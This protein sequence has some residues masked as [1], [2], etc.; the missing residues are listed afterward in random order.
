MIK[1]IVFLKL[2]D[3]SEQNKQL[4]KD[5]IMSMKGKIDVLKHIEVGVNF[6]K[7]ERA[8]D[9]SLISDFKTKE[10]LQAY[11]VNPLHVEIINYLKSKNTVTKVVDYEY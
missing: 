11:A 1:H 7:E 5:K 8:Y 2:E 10:D 6:S 9:L 3:N 4:V